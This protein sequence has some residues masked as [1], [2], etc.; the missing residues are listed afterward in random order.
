[1]CGRARG[2][3]KFEMIFLFC[4]IPMAL[5]QVAAQMTVCLQ[6]G[7]VAGKQRRSEYLKE[8]LL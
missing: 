5:S 8:H 4:L 2:F 3:V 6:L 1:V 7:F